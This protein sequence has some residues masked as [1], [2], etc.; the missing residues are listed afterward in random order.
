M[1]SPFDSP[2][3]SPLSIHLKENI[4]QTK[5]YFEEEN[6]RIRKL[7]RTSWFFEHFFDNN[8]G[9]HSTQQRVTEF[10]D[11]SSIFKSRKQIIGNNKDNTKT[12]NVNGK[13]KISIT[14]NCTKI[15]FE[16]INNNPMKNSSNINKIV[17]K[18]VDMESSKKGNAKKNVRTK[19]IITLNVSKN[20]RN[21]YLENILK[22]KRINFKYNFEISYLKKKETYV[23]LLL[24]E[25]ISILYEIN[26]ILS[27]LL[28]RE[29][30]TSY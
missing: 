24:D 19:E 8:S 22:H 10:G 23:K 26:L 4:Q 21:A 29:I 13:S 27:W 6:L 5:S 2:C 18:N 12:N 30:L 14:A 7:K 25:Q 28:L 20:C 3:D 1:F 11:L 15:N 16:N 9:I 17:N